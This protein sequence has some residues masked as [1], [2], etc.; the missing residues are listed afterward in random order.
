MR[1]DKEWVNSPDHYNQSK[2]ELWDIFLDLGCAE[3]YCVSSIYKYV[4]RHKEKNGVQ[5]LKKA[6]ACLDFLIE[7]YDEIFEETSNED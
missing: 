3:G 1:R 5:D 2:K 4:Y 7:H 6:R